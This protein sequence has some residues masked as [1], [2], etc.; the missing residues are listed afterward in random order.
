MRDFGI[1]LTVCGIF[2]II[3]LILIMALFIYN[4]GGVYDGSGIWIVIINLA[5]GIALITSGRGIS[6][7]ETEP[8]GIKATAIASIVIG[9]IFLFLGGLKLGG[10]IIIIYAII[11]LVKVGRYEEWFYGEVE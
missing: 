1:I 5:L 8:S 11:A 3:G 9:T 6:K 7:L 10:L 4:N 2:E